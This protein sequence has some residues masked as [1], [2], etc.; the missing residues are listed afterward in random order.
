MIVCETSY[1]FHSHQTYLLEK[2]VP[3]MKAEIERDK[4]D[5]DLETEK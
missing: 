2:L 3:Q 1:G 5:L 4:W